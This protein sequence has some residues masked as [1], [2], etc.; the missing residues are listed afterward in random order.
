MEG[1]REETKEEMEARRRAEGMQEPLEAVKKMG[2]KLM[3]TSHLV[4]SQ[5]PS[6]LRLSP[7]PKTDGDPGAAWRA[8]EL[9]K[10]TLPRVVVEPQENL[11]Q[12]EDMAPEDN[13]VPMGGYFIAVGRFMGADENG[14][15]AI[16]RLDLPSDLAP[17]W[18]GLTT[19]PEGGMVRFS[20]GVRRDL[21]ERGLMR[22]LRFRSGEWV[23]S[24]DRRQKRGDQKAGEANPLMAHVVQIVCPTEAEKHPEAWDSSEYLD[25][26]ASVHAWRPMQGRKVKAVFNELSPLSLARGQRV[27]VAIAL[28]RDEAEQQKYRFKEATVDEDYQGHK[29]CGRAGATRRRWRSASTTGRRARFPCIRS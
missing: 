20:E 22:P 7:I 24:W 23:L 18:E 10:V 8:G 29:I 9:I 3:G 12:E 13:D 27:A 14:V 11:F 15:L 19:D 21:V 17:Q 16:E 28:R 1:S 6:D 26:H 2:T 25:E 5:R 4:G